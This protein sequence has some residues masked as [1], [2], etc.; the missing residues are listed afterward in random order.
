MNPAFWNG[1]GVFLTGHTGFKGAWLALWLQQSGARVT[2]YALDPPTVPSLF[3]LAQVAGGMTDIRGDVRDRSALATAM[4]RAQPEV[5][6]HMAAQALVRVS[7][8]A[9][10]ETYAT[11]VMGTAHVL[12]ALRHAPSARAAVIVTSDK[13]YE[14][15]E[16]DRGYR[17]DDAMGGHDPYSSSKAC[18]E[19]VTAAFR[20]SFFDRADAPSVAIASA[21]AGN[22]IGGGDWARDRLMPDLLAAFAARKPAA[23]RN[24]MATRPW[25]HVLEPLRGYLTLAERL[26]SGDRRAAGAWNFGPRPSAIRSV[27]AVADAA[28]AAWGAGAS[29][30]QDPQTHPHEAHA[31]DLDISKAER[32]LGWHPALDVDEAIEWTVRWHAELRDGKAPRELT[33]RAIS[34]YERLVAAGA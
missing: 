30:I 19:L 9:P 7:Y 10:I 12:D 13:A 14:N 4:D 26:A 16:W 11:N 21:R 32:D 25:Q 23:I 15:R 31:L 22:V 34:R 28:V 20:R 17:E 29:W 5:V 2:G 27:A 6:F 18:A 3:E 24:P 1:R 8:E 33:A